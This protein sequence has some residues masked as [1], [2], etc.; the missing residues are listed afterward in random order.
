M[1]KVV[2]IEFNTDY[3]FNTGTELILKLFQKEKNDK[4]FLGSF[5]IKFNRNECLK[6]IAYTVLNLTQKHN[7]IYLACLTKD[8][9][10]VEKTLVS[11]GCNVDKI[12]FQDF[13]RKL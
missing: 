2:I 4:I 12:L 9:L 13:L 10:E 11:K 6:Q 3:E 7:V 1:T 8:V 5:N